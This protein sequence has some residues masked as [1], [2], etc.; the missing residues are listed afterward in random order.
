VV[1]AVSGL[2]PIPILVRCH[3][4]CRLEATGELVDTIDV[5]VAGVPIGRQIMRLRPEERS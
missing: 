1:Q 5:S 3:D 4:V 2:L